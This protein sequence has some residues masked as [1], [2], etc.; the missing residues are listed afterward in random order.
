MSNPKNNTN[1]LSE[2]EKEGKDKGETK[3]EIHHHIPGLVTIVLK[4]EPLF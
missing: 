4:T 3:V 2:E 1:K